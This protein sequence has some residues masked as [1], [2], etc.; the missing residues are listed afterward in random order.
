MTHTDNDLRAEIA[1]ILGY[2]KANNGTYLESFSNEYMEDYEQADPKIT[3]ILNLFTQKLEAIA[4][5]LPEMTL[6]ETI[7]A[8]MFPNPD[9][10]KKMLWTL[11]T[12]RDK[13]TALLNNEIKE[14]K[15]KP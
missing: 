3:A 10:Y 12:Y 14:L 1:E 2:I 9:E 4:A 8:D 7:D 11:E 5:G 15:G 13:V 6:N